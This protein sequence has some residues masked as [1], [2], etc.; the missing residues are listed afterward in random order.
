MIKVDD[1]TRDKCML[2]LPVTLC[3]FL[4]AQLLYIEDFL[5]EKRK[6]LE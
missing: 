5:E 6:T 4:A 3:A 1:M 2:L